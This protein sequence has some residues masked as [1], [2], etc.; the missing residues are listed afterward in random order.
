MPCI[1]S[2]GQCAFLRMD[3]QRRESTLALRFANFRNPLSH[4]SHASHT[5]HLHSASRV[6][7]RF[8]IGFSCSFHSVKPLDGRKNAPALNRR[9]GIL[10]PC[11][12]KWGCALRDVKRRPLFND[13]VVKDQVGLLRICLQISKREALFKASGACNG[14]EVLHGTPGRRH[15]ISTRKAADCLGNREPPADDR[16]VERMPPAG[17]DP[18]NTS[19]PALCGA[20]PWGGLAVPQ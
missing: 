17:R 6:A 18:E 8:A 7:P 14:R 12:R 2:Q 19:R 10:P 16:R 1:L 9:D 3:R 15:G 11:P 5:S 20:S 4:A 13:S